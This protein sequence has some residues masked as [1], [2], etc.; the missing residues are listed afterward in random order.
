MRERRQIARLGSL[1]PA[2]FAPSRGRSR[3]QLPPP[4]P[5]NSGSSEAPVP[6]KKRSAGEKRGKPPPPSGEPHSWWLEAGQAPT[7]FVFGPGYLFASRSSGDPIAGLEQNVAAPV[8]A[9]QDHVLLEPDVTVIRESAPPS[10]VA[11]VQPTP[12]IRI[13]NKQ[14]HSHAFRPSDC[15]PS[16]RVWLRQGGEERWRKDGRH[17]PSGDVCLRDRRPHAI[18]RQK[19]QLII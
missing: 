7:F 1:G 15:H 5:V 10:E 11:Q 18:E 19:V 2:E 4:A 9:G 17:R 16:T 6:P 13:P 3:V 14:G 12:G 8:A